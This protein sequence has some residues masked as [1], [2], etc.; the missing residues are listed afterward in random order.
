MARSLAPRPRCSSSS[1]RSIAGAPGSRAPLRVREVGAPS[2]HAAPCATLPPRAPLAHRV[3]PRT[4]NPVGRVRVPHGACL[5]DVGTRA[6]LKTGLGRL[7]AVGACG[8]AEAGQA[9][10][11]AMTSWNR[12]D[13]LPQAPIGV[14]RLVLR[15]L[16]SDKDER[17]WP[18]GAVVHHVGN[19]IV[20]LDALV[21]L[22]DA[23]LVPRRP[24]RQNRNTPH[25]NRA[26]R[27]RPA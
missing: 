11:L 12:P 26:S 7:G 8:G 4:F 6:P 14:Q 24:R 17:L 2:R 18:L 19:P 5:Y 22:S 27:A 13:H 15:L 9:V 23:G 3:E 25:R 20:A 10:D 16:L 1:A 21:A